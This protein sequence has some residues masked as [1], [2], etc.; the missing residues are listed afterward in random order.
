[1]SSK[2]DRPR[3]KNDVMLILKISAILDFRHPIIGSLKIQCRT[4][5]RPPI[6]TIA[7]NCL[8]LRKSHFYVRILAI[9]TDGQTDKQTDR[10]TNGLTDRQPQR[11]KL[12][13]CCVCT[14]SLFHYVEKTLNA[15]IVMC[16]SVCRS[17]SEDGYCPSHQVDFIQTS[18]VHLL[19]TVYG[20]LDIKLNY[21]V[22]SEHS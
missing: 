20:D 2:L 6:D 11:I 3:K 22:D 14:S 16:A 8:V 1:M 5:Y 19:E 18:V 7:L 17:S 15:M 21:S 4:S 12:N 13:K 9:E 10:Q